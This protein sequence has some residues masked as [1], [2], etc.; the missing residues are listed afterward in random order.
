MSAGGGGGGSMAGLEALQLLLKV[1]G[2]YLG[3]GGEGGSNW[4]LGI[5]VRVGGWGD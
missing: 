5:Q 3:G 4:G 1:F 2:D